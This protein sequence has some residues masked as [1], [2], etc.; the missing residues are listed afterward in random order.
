MSRKGCCGGSTS[1]FIPGISGGESGC[2]FG[3]VRYIYTTLP[4][5]STGM[6]LKVSSLSGSSVVWYS[7]DVSVRFQK[8]GCGSSCQEAIEYKSSAVDRATSLVT[9]TFD[10]R[11][12]NLCR[13]RYEAI[14]TV[15]C[16]ELPCRLD[17]KIGQTLCVED[18]D[19]SFIDTVNADDYQDPSCC[20]NEC[21]PK[22]CTPCKNE[23]ITSEPERCITIDYSLSDKEQ[24]LFDNFVA[25]ASG[26]QTD[27]SPDAGEI[28]IKLSGG[29]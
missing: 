25:R 29:S 14:F 9:F 28:S 22:D 8:R 10:D 13:G 19:V 3:N 20:E 15:G 21:A 4:P 12:L 11:F 16:Y 27:T 17:F 26:N 23:S 6:N 5:L 24:T 1:R 7:D 18:V 2:N